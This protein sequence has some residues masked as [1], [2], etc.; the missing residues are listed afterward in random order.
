LAFLTQRL[1][2]VGPALGLG[3]F[4]FTR[5]LKAVFGLGNLL[6]GEVFALRFVAARPEWAARLV[7]L[8]PVVALPPA[9]YAASSPWQFVAT[10]VMLVPLAALLALGTLYALRHIRRLWAENH[11][12][13]TV[14]LLWI[15]PTAAFAIWYFPENVHFWTPLLIPL[16]AVVALV[17]KDA[18]AHVPHRRPL[19]LAAL[20]I[21]LLFGVNFVG[22]ILPAHNPASNWNRDVAQFIGQHTEP[23]DLI[24]SLEAGEYKHLPPNVTY[25]AGNLVFTMRGVFFAPEAEP[26]LRRHIED[27]FAQGHSVYLF[28]DVFQSRT[29]HIGIARLSGLTEDEVRE[30]I[31]GLFAGCSLTLVANH[32]RHPPLYRV[33]ECDFEDR[34]VYDGDLLPYEVVKRMPS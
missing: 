28:G 12:V 1:Q 15:V 25:Y 29:G 33:T 10:M 22:S 34:H 5:S 30:R 31:E 18:Q 20:T 9:S 4:S 8:T 23:E 6:L 7:R 27:T 13:F 24:I 14:L 32:P 3:Q 26:A 17:L 21:V 16:G 2:T 11:H 19:V